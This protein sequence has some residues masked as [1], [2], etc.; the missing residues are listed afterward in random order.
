MIKRDLAITEKIVKAAGIQPEWA[1]AT[2]TSEPAS[3]GRPG[4]RARP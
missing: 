2:L 3:P 4:A 1:K